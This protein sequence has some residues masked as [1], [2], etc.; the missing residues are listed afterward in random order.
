ML[1]L[2]HIRLNR[3]DHHNTIQVHIL[4]VSGRQAIANAKGTIAE[5]LITIS[6]SMTGIPPPNL[7]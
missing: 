2:N 4:P 1:P 6:G 7:S 5:V 3:V